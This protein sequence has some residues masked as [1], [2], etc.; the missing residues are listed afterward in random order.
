MFR[1]N[2]IVQT[3]FFLKENTALGTRLRNPNGE[4]S[5][6]V[7]TKST[8]TMMAKLWDLFNYKQRPLVKVKLLESGSNKRS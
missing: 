1:Y 6:V 5:L 2:M 8:E 3:S 7:N 4:S